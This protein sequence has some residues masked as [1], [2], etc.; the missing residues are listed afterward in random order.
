MG[1]N[2]NDSEGTLLHVV[3]H[4]PTVTNLMV[5]LISGADLGGLPVQP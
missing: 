5:N 3:I 1:G 4:G 2:V